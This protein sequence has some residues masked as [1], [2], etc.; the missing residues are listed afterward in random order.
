[1]SNDNTAEAILALER[2]ALD[3]YSQGNPLGYIDAFADDASYF[4]DI[5]AHTR[6]DGIEAVRAHFTEL[7]KAVPPHEYEL[8]NPRVQL[9]GEVGI[10]TLRYHGSMADGEPLP[11]WKATVVY[12]NDGDWKVVHA[13]WSLVKE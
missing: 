7:Q 3:R 8:V 4:D 9:Y 11:Q 6:L 1:M 10:L 12:R 13:H 2:R 5:A